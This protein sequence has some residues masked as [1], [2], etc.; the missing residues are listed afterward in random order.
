[1][2]TAKRQLAT[3]ESNDEYTRDRDGLRQYLYDV[4]DELFPFDGY[5]D[6]QDEILRKSLEALFIDGYDNII[7]EGPTGIGKSPI[8]ITIGRVVKHLAKNKETIEEYFQ[9]PLH[10]IDTGKSFYTTPQKQ[11]RNQLAN[12]EDLKEYVQMLKSRQDYICGAS[13]DNCK[14]C[15]LGSESEDES[16]RTIPGCTYWAEKEK[17]MHGDISALTFAMLVVDNHIPE[18]D[19]NGDKLSFGNRDCVIVDE[20]HN[21]ENQVASLFAGFSVSSWVLPDEVYK[22]TSAK[23]QWNFERYEDVADII[24]GLIVRANDY[25]E[26]WED[27]PSKEIQVEQCENFVQKAGF[28][29][30]EVQ[31]GRPWVVTVDTLGTTGEKKMTLKPVD[32]DNFLQKFIWSRG[33]KRVISSATIP[34]RDKID[35]WAD[36]IGLDGSTK[37]ISRPMPFPEEN[38]LIHKDTIVASM[39]GDGEEDN[40]G[41][42][43]AEVQNLAEKHSGQKGLIHTTSYNRAEKLAKRLD[44]DNAMVQD[45]DKDKSVVIAEWQESDKDIL[46]SPS[47]TE[48]VDLYDDRCR[49]QVMLKIPYAY[50]GD[51]RVSYLLNERY[52]WEWYNQTAML[53]VIQSVGRAVRGPEDHASYYVIDGAFEKLMSKVST[54]DWFNSAIRE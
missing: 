47:M 20:G 18:L 28:C 14:E 52:D 39:S 37:H 8:N 31:N 24:D 32:V 54:P 10:G 15:S 4:A 23:I 40:W 21:L 44:D 19:M 2:S 11:L 51:S 43:V 45:Q 5:R 48:G 42:V 49:W 17:A 29:K 27:A 36:R 46:L 33:N 13:G 30:N 25:I 50:I 34:Y 35:V 6:Y 16:C 22:G 26:K 53:D 1:M 3:G 38:R 12:D 9:Y 41:N 7:I